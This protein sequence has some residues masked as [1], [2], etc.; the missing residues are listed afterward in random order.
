[1]KRR[2]MIAALAAASVL[3]CSS[4]VFAG[5]EG[6]EGCG[7][8]VG[9]QE[10]EEK[11]DFFEKLDDFEDD[12]KREAYFSENG[13]G[14]EENSHSEANPDS[15]ELEKE[16]IIDAETEEVIKEYAHA[17]HERIHSS[18]ENMGEMTAEERHT[19]HENRASERLDAVGSMERD[20]KIT[21]EEAAK[22]RAYKK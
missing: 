2:I 9:Q 12:G 8:S 22:I 17:K 13:V 7:F 19:A 16:G 5:Y 3:M 20:G 1:M 18:Y 4:V 6:K 15:E 14:D 10:N 21:S 11:D